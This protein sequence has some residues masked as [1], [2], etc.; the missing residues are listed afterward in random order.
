MYSDQNKIPYSTKNPIQIYP[1]AK[2]LNTFPLNDFDFLFPDLPTIKIKNLENWS[3]FRKNADIYIVTGEENRQQTD[4]IY[5]YIV[6]YFKSDTKTDIKILKDRI[7]KKYGEKSR[8]SLQKFLKEKE[9]YQGG[10]NGIKSK[11]F[12]EAFKNYQ[13]FLKVKETGWINIETASK[14]KK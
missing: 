2:C 4:E 12:E 5:G 8:K 11:E 7:I 9:F 10:I 13:K 6:E 1:C 14:M 3:V